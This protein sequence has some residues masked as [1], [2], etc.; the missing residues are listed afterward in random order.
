MK[1]II[2][3]GALG[4]ITAVLW[5]SIDTFE[6]SSNISLPTTFTTVRDLVER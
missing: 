5:L 2:T 1:S 4:V 3:L 6:R